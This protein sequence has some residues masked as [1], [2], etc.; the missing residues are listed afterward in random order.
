MFSNFLSSAL[1]SPIL[2]TIK[3]LSL[4]CIILLYLSLSLSC[5]KTASD[6]EGFLDFTKSSDSD[7]FL[8]SDQD[9]ESKISSEIDADEPS[10]ISNLIKGVGQITLDFQANTFTKNSN[11][12][13]EKVDA[14]DSQYTQYS[15]ISGGPAVSILPNDV[16]IQPLRPFVDNMPG[17]RKGA[18][19]FVDT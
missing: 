16:E 4:F 14:I 7:D 12:N 5:K 1:I 2:S 19:C 10:R 17:A 6:E 8:D 18:A 13:V 15:I 11:V 3:K 9:Y